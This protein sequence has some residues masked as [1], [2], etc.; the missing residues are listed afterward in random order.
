MTRH[1][2][3]ACGLFP[4]EAMEIYSGTTSKSDHAFG[5]GVFVTDI[6]D[7]ARQKTSGYEYLD[8]GFTTF[9]CA[10]LSMYANSMQI[11]RSIKLE[12]RIIFYLE[13]RMRIF[14]SS[15]VGHGQRIIVLA[16]L[17]STQTRRVKYKIRLA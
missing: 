2:F 7:E 14:S 16:V 4:C 3:S 6:P 12:M 13:I 8:N 15:P 9:Q 17:L 10:L 5:S 11:E 1:P